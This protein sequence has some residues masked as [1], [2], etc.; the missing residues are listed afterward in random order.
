MSE[1]PHLKAYLC[2]DCWGAIPHFVVA[3]KEEPKPKNDT[4]WTTIAL[5]TIGNMVC[6]A[7]IGYYLWL[8]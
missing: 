2:D 8:K 3:K 6:L 1:E 5:Y 4:S 7:I